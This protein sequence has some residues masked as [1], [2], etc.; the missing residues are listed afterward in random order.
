M[1][2][3]SCLK[4][5]TWCPV[6]YVSFE[7]ED[8]FLEGDYDSRIQ[9]DI[10]FYIFRSDTLVYAQI[11]PYKDIANG[12]EYA[13]PKTE[14]FIG[15]LKLVAWAVKC[16]VTDHFN[17]GEPLTIHN[18]LHHPEYAL[19]SLYQDQRLTLSQIE[20]SAYD[21]YSPI[22]HERYI[23]TL[24]PTE[25]ELWSRHSYHDIFMQSA[26][27]RIMVNIND[28][29]GY[30]SYNGQ[31]H[32]VVEGTMSQ[33][34]LGEPNDGRDGRHGVGDI[35]AV[36]A[37]IGQVSPETR[38]AGDPTHTTGIFGLL[39]SQSNTSLK[40]HVMSGETTL[41]TYIIDAEHTENRFA[42][43]RSGDLITFDIYDLQSSEV[44]IT[45]NGYTIK[46][47]DQPPL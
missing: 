37:D 43:L 25:D 1:S 10:Q 31:P 20:S 2:L 4:E 7:L 14:E 42:A 19:G 47:V 6:M 8:Q 12:A 44:E 17:G 3:C 9:N 28:P 45:I 41:K 40:V 30:L 16:D 24:D 23:G 13:I 46:N 26:P 33:M 34:I 32:V 39:P 11:I 22:H 36:R 29:G 5:D 18:D 27:G 21:H 15:D 38:A 35:V